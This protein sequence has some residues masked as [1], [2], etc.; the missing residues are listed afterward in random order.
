MDLVDRIGPLSSALSRL[1][2]RASTSC[3]T[4]DRGIS[5]RLQGQLGIRHN[6][7]RS[8]DLTVGVRA[9]APKSS[10]LDAS[11]TPSKPIGRY[12]SNGRM[13]D[14]WAFVPDCTSTKSA[15]TLHSANCPS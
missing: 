13:A 1:W 9:S 11:W 6:D 7:R 8:A 14:D 15:R 12:S 5:P 2:R 10:V 3:Y 4:A